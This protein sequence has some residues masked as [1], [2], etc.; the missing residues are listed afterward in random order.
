M[1]TPGLTDG[2]V[3]GKK[4]YGSAARTASLPDLR[5]WPGDGFS[6]NPVLTPGLTAGRVNG[7]KN[8]LSAMLR[9]QPR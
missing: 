2:R 8:T 9:G 3:S 4:H 1:P 7:E 5:R 6:G